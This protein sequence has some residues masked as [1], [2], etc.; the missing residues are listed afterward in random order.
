MTALSVTAALGSRNSVREFS[1]QPVSRETLE[2]LLTLAGQ[3]PSGGNLQPWQ[4][5]VLTGQ[6]IADLSERVFNSM[7]DRGGQTEPEFPTYPAGLGSPYR[8]RRAECGERMYSALGISREDR[9]R[10]IAQ[11][12]QNYRFFGAPV[13]ILLTMDRDMDM[14][15]C[16]DLGIYLQ[17]LMLAAREQGLDTCPQVSWTVWPQAVR[18]ALTLPD[19]VRVMAGVCL[20]YR[21]LDAAVN[22]VRQPRA[23]LTDYVTWRGFD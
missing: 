21:A 8:E 7:Q 17:S 5:H 4:V 11:V 1:N 22:R 19:S 9:D 23:P 14:P 10:R 3:A 6:A 18:E 13:G 15:Q 2:T 20:G 12:M 16:L